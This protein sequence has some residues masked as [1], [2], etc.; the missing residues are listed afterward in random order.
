MSTDDTSKVT[1][2]KIGGT[3]RAFAMGS[4]I[5]GD[6]A[7]EL[8]GN[9]VEQ[10][11][12]YWLNVGARLA[13]EFPERDE[14]LVEQFIAGASTSVPR[15]ARPAVRVE[16]DNTDGEAFGDPDEDADESVVR[17][18]VARILRAAADR[19]ENYENEGVLHD[20]NGAKAGR[21]NAD[22]WQ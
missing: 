21:F 4:M 18:E 10:A 11:A 17:G 12:V 14:P 16:I 2:I 5:G 9:P 20:S 1:T 13:A 22:F 8:T 19:I 15:G 7:G 3:L 6:L